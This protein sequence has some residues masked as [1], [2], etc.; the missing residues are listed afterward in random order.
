MAGIPDLIIFPLGLAAAS[1]VAGLIAGLLGVGGGIV[2]VPVLYWMLPW[3]GAD[4]AMR[5]HVA[6]ATS[7][8]TIIATGFVSAR[9]HA[10][11]GNIAWDV[12]KEWWLPVMAGTIVGAMVAARLKGDLLTGIFATLAFVVAIR[13][14]FFG[15]GEETAA[16]AP[17]RPVYWLAAGLTGFVSSLMGIGGGTLSVPALVAFKHPMRR[18]VGTAAALGLVIALPGTI[19]FILEGWGEPGLPPYSAGYVNFLAVAIIIPVT[20]TMA[21][22]GARLAH[23]ANP[24]LLRRIF[25]LFLGVTAI[26]MGLNVLG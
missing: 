3:L 14:G 4:E 19:T 2:L 7:L 25:A 8:A 21:P 22:V 12:L 9:S 11:R 26:R 13:L 23:T 10:K 15:K 6:V 20:M 5:M 24:I 18:A 17:P 1:V 16:K